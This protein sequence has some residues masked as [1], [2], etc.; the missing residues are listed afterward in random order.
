MVNN[1]TGKRINPSS[2]DSVNCYVLLLEEIPKAEA[3]TNIEERKDDLTKGLIE[4]GVNA[5]DINICLDEDDFVDISDEY[6]AVKKRALAK[7]GSKML[8]IVAFTGH[9]TVNSGTLTADGEYGSGPGLEG[10]AKDLASIEGNDV[11]A[12][13]DCC[14][15]SRGEAG[16]HHS[17]EKT[18][19]IAC[20]YRT[21]MV[22]CVRKQACPCEP[23]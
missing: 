15:K 5:D 20:I 13:F 22:P 9:S 11:I 8:T 21:E 3:I 4:W 19:N 7:P 16:M 2:Y 14:R 23:W 6:T 17:V 12:I 1:M 10:F 18:A